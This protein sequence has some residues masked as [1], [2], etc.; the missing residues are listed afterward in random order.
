[1]SSVELQ[2]LDQQLQRLLIDMEGTKVPQ[3]NKAFTEA[4]DILSR[5]VEDID[6]MIETLKDSCQTSWKNIWRSA[7]NGTSL[8]VQKLQT[9][10]T[11]ALESKTNC[12]NQVLQLIAENGNLPKK[13]I[14]TECTNILCDSSKVQYIG[15][16]FMDI[17]NIQIFQSQTCLTGID[18]KDWNNLIT[19]I[20]K[21]YNETV[22]RDNVIMNALY[23][24]IKVGLENFPLS[25]K[26]AQCLN[27]LKEFFE[28]NRRPQLREELLKVRNKFI[29][30]FNEDRH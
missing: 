19:I 29:S 25:N 1:M 21:L 3:R 28:E 10:S 14:F 18:K 26:L 12:Y 23:N 2:T 13:D 17:L 24:V 4:A 22:F 9:S 27:N 30:I 16:R 5:R 8:H 20:F 6:A 11:S 7:C 15:M